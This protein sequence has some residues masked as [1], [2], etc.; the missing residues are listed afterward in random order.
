MPVQDTKAVGWD[1]IDSIDYATIAHLYD[2]AFM[3]L[4]DGTSQVPPGGSSAVKLQPSP[5]MVPGCAQIVAA[6]LQ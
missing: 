4:S 1:I 5:S 6:I 3:R 2:R